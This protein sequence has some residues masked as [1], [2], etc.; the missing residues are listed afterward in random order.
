MFPLIARVLGSKVATQAVKT[1]AK[2]LAQSSVGKALK[3]KAGDYV[4]NIHADELKLHANML[5]KVASERASTIGNAAASRFGRAA[6][7]ARRLA[8]EY[9]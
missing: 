1:G 3:K 9:E 7:A 4:G 6:D 8:R 5:K 2:K